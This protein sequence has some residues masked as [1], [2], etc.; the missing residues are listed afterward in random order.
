MRDYC[1]KKGF[2]LQLAAVLLLLLSGCAGFSEAAES[3]AQ[4]TPTV[5]TEPVRKAREGLQTVLALGLDSYQAP[6]D[7]GAYRNDQRADFILLLILDDELGKTTS[8]QLNPDTVV[9]F[10]PPGTTENLD[11]PLGLVYSYGSG[12]SDSCLNTTKAVSKL[13]GGISIE[14][15]MTFTVDS[16]ATVNDMLGGVTVTATE[17]FPAPDGEETLT[18]LGEASAEYFRFRAAEDV[19]NEAHM[20][21]QRQ[22]MMGLYSPFAQS[23]RQENFL[24]KLTLQ[25]GDALN[26]D[27]TLSQMTFML[28]NLGAYEMDETIMT[29]PGSARE[30][31]GEFLFYVDADSLERT[32]EDLFFTE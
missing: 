25:L 17:D 26:T 9:P 2:A 27:L 16:I 14:H 31:D 32:V 23:A 20:G 10:S 15:Y 19:A 6:R 18:L 8:L 11:I 4:K 21:R 24:T 13:L 29:I 30:A 28:E 3:S 1:L 22:Y 5:I 12:G 7:S